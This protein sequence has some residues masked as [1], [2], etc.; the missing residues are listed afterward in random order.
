MTN[1][2]DMLIA[3][4]AGEL[5][6]SEAEKA[7]ALLTQYV[8]QDLD[9]GT[10]EEIDR[11]VNRHEALAIIVA[12]ARFGKSWFDDTLGQELRPKLAKAEASPEL[13]A[14]VERLAKT[15]APHNDGAIAA[16]RPSPPKLGSWGWYALAA[17]IVLALIAGFG[18]QSSLRSRLNEAEMAQARAHQRLDQ[19]IAENRRIAAE[20]DELENRL[21]DQTERLASAGSLQAALKRELS[22]AMAEAQKLRSESSGLKDRLATT[23]KQL[24]A[25]EEEAG[26]A[27]RLRTTLSDVQTLRRMAI[28]SHRDR[29][30]ALETE[31]ARLE[32]ALAEALELEQTMRAELAESELMMTALRSEAKGSRFELAA[33]REAL[34]DQ[35][36]ELEARERDLAELKAEVDD[37]RSAQLATTQAEEKLR[38]DAV[39]ER[40][41]SSW[42]K[43]VVGYYSVYARQPR[44]HL[45][46]VGAD[47]R[48]HLGQ[49]LGEQ[50]GRAV[51]IP[52]LPEAKM[53][54]YG[55]RLL[56]IDGMPVGQLVYLDA[57][58]RPLAFCLMRNQMGKKKEL[59]L[60]TQND[61][62]LVEWSD[63]AYQYVIVAPT[64]FAALE[65]VAQGFG[66]NYNN[67]L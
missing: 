19:E 17:S 11:L 54:F 49:W 58:D 57:E 65:A 25:V 16:Q 22:D 33:L 41:R 39:N 21:E 14:F 46:E 34:A 27:R 60:S 45:V 28:A 37:L 66:V 62:Q 32:A 1:V 26:E 51:P 43:Q 9:A 4:S 50:L 7:E 42:T 36:A 5:S 12:D 2:T 35:T 15:P 63:D 55:G 64:T 67:D 61:L 31:L 56:V 53:R 44:R 40:P 29:I 13:R 6:E 23:L 52:D 30:G 20:R 47:E 38:A 24:A 18:F 8:G 3:Y 10:I 59:E 48:D